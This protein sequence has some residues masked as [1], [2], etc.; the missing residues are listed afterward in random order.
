MLHKF[1]CRK[2]N[3]YKTVEKF[4]TT[5]RVKH[6]EFKINSQNNNTTHNIL[7]SRDWHILSLVVSTHLN[8]YIICQFPNGCFFCSVLQALPSGPVGNTA[9]LTFLVLQLHDKREN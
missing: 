1:I 7:F 8:K 4:G 6:H 9:P 2:Y 3:L 5:L